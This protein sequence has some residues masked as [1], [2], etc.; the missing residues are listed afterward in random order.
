[1]VT[2]A[3]WA[4]FVHQEAGRAAAARHGPIGYLAREL[5]D[6]IPA[7]LALKCQ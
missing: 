6:E 4:A 1:A 7:V 3:C 5:L 2:A